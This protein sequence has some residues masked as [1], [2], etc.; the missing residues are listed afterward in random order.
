MSAAAICQRRA[1]TQETGIDGR[2]PELRPEN[3]VDKPVLLLKGEE[4]LGRAK[5]TRFLNLTSLA[6]PSTPFTAETDRARLVPIVQAIGINGVTLRS[7]LGKTTRL[8]LVNSGCRIVRQ[9]I[10]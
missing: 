5:Q 3:N 8:T 1:S 2:V 4:L 9:G 6:P 7:A 10:C